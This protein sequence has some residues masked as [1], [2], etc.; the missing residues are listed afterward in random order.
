VRVVYPRTTFHQMRQ[1]YAPPG[2]P[3]HADVRRA[4]ARLA[5]ERLPLPSP[6]DQEELR[7]P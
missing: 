3:Q 2:S 1:V 5:D 6:E 4:L 7:S